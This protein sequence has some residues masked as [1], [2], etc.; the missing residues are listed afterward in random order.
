MAA[1]EGRLSVDHHDLRAGGCRTEFE[2]APVAAIA[3]FEHRVAL[4]WMAAHQT[5]SGATPELS[6]ARG[7]T[8][9][10]GIVLE[11]SA[12]WKMGRGEP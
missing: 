8:E 5:G 11:P 3:E 1:R 12:W 6:D 4:E 10:L 7:R 9:K 2:H